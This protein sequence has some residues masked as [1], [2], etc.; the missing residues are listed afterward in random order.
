MDDTDSFLREED[1]AMS[2]SFEV[3]PDIEVSR[4]SV[5][6]M[7]DASS[8]A[9]DGQ[10]EDLVDVFSGGTVGIGGLDE[11]NLELLVEAGLTSYFD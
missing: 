7:F 10:L 1:C 3:N 5:V 9:Y 11:A 8:G 4:C 6:K 2:V